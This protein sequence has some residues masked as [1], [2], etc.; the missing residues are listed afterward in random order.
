MDNKLIPRISATLKYGAFSGESRKRII[1]PYIILVSIFVFGIILF[2][3]MTSFDYLNEKSS[4]TEY[5]IGIVAI[6]VGFLSVP[7]VLLFLII[8]N[9]K[10]RKHILVWID[11]AVELSAYC[12]NIGVKHWIGI[13]LTKLQVEFNINGVTYVRTTDI[14]R[15]SLF[16]F[17][18]P[19]GFL[20]SMSKY[21]DKSIKILYSPK[22]DEVMILKD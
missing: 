18:R 15:R 9:E 6:T 8:R 22:Y 11:D 14:E 20:A 12:K 10:I 13:Q 1:I 3:A 21:A 7:C 16:N 2:I 4:L 5:I 19:L 17:G